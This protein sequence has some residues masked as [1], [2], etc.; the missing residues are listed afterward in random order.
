MEKKLLKTRPEKNYGSITY[1]RTNDL[2]IAK[3]VME[4]IRCSEVRVKGGKGSKPR[5]N[6]Q[7]PEFRTNYELIF[8]HA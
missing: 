3:S 4:K 5:T 7:N 6:P 2:E 1:T 8:Q